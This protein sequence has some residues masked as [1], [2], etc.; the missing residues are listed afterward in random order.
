MC[1]R[2][3]NTADTAEWRKIMTKSNFEKGLDLRRKM[4]G[5]E[6][7][8][9][10]VDN[11]STHLAPMQDIVT[12]ICFG[13]VWQRPVLDLK[14]RSLLTL[15]M[16][17]AMGRQHEIKIHTKGA[18][19]NGVTR[20]EIR[21]MMVHAFLYCGIPLM[22]D[23]LRA[24]EEVLDQL[25]PEEKLKATNDRIGFIGLG[26]MGAP[27]SANIAK[28]GFRLTVYD[29]DHAL[30]RKHAAEIGA[31]AAASLSEL[32]RNCDIVVTMLPTGA[33]VK[34]V[35]L[36]EEGGLAATLSRGSLIVDMSSSEP[37]GSR[38]VAEALA[39]R[40]V[41]F[42]DA[43]V[44][45]AVPRAISG[46]LSI[47]AGTSDPALLER[48][49]PVLMAMGQ[50]VFET[51]GIGSGHALKAL[52][53]YVAA[54]GFAAASEAL[55]VGE[56]FGLDPK[57]ALDVMNVST[58]RN[59][60][61]E[62]TIKSQVLT[63]EYASGFQLGLLTKDVG[64]A[65][66][67][68]E[69]TGGK[70]PLVK[71]TAKWWRKACEK[72]GATQD[73]TAA[74]KAWRGDA[75][76]APKAAKPASTQPASA[77]QPANGAQRYAMLIDGRPRT[78][79]DYLPVKNPANGDTVGY[80]PLG[81][82]ADLDDAVAAARKAFPGWAATPDGERKAACHA[83]A[84]KIEA[85][86]EELARL[87][88]MEQGK[89]LNGPG[90]R[91]EAQGSAGWAHFTAD[92]ELPVETIQDTNEGRVEVHRKPIGVVGSIT[93]WNW[94]MLIAVW[95]I[96]PAVRTGNTVVIKPSPYTPLSTIRLV[97]LMNEVLPEGVVNVVTG[98]DAIGARMSSHPGIDKMVFTGSIATGKKIMSSSAE[99]LKR[100]TLELGGNDAGIVL[101]DADPRQIAEGL[102][103]GAFINGGQTCAALKRLYVHDSIYEDVCR[104]LSNLAA[105]MP[106]GNGLDEANVLGPIQN[107][108]QF[109]KVV[110]LVEDAKR[111]GARILTG[112]ERLDGQGYFYP[113]TLVADV[114][115][116]VPLVDE[117]QFG[118]VLPIIRYSDI[119]SI[120]GKANDN[121]HGLGGS[122]WSSDVQKA[123]ELAVQLE[124][125][126]AW[127]NKH[128]AIQ[129]NA[130]FGGVK[131]SGIG[132]EFGADGLKEYT[133]SQ[134]LFS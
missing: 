48:A 46:T 12:R 78:A 96:L 115:H 47:M 31:Q 126:S 36:E 105:N 111:R 88:T 106:M 59:F 71:R 43:P 131:S 44:S 60:S 125:G 51:G 57:V 104:E 102:F 14:T 18:L 98:P 32:G 91:F 121:P 3:S 73:H 103:W 58:G 66:D 49:R 68:A 70:M 128:G 55:I 108:M 54:A 1:G 10:Q 69:Q 61:T 37:I 42:I 50:K 63:G 26:N 77:S 79:S 56:R 109:N 33:I 119:N 100:L 7:A 129:P 120:I 94:P 118:P 97:E 89:P 20:E 64:I 16:L 35:L 114:D 84:S 34:K 38:E 65:A 2:Q 132:V 134:T 82:V 25:A 52:N 107:E 112:G 133:V 93:P 45:G 6:G 83:I 99:T 21:E 27:M 116:G 130:P 74:Y 67:L 75:S 17:T 8:E 15:A 85:H 23:A 124:C 86:A 30:A 5:P 110:A 122:I 101:P 40:G 127:V 123:R 39:A 76:E 24:S 80:M 62:S 72:M 13:E 90:S 113:V 9:L 95:H 29:T 11:A 53:N 92:L 4:F 22:V 87:I 28:A 41:S 117:E 19:A 81:T